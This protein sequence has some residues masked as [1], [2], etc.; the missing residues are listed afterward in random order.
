MH[1][2]GPLLVRRRDDDDGILTSGTEAKAEAEGRKRGGRGGG[3][4][5][6]GP[7]EEVA[8]SLLGAAARHRDHF[9]LRMGESIGGS[10]AGPEANDTGGAGRRGHEGERLLYSYLSAHRHR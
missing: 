1:R 3:R 10:Y 5:S 2:K 7:L 9:H 8:E 6:D 4:W